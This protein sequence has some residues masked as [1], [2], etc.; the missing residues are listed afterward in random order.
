MAVHDQKLFPIPDEDM[1][2][3]DERIP[4]FVMLDQKAIELIHN[5][6]DQ[7]KLPNEVCQDILLL[8]FAIIQI[9]SWRGNGCETTIEELVAKSF[10]DSED[11]IDRIKWLDDLKLIRGALQDR[12]DGSKAI[13]IFTL[14]TPRPEEVGL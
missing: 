10:I 2:V 7:E 3:Y 11:F 12:L 5:K 8:Y 4:P 1:I 6:F 14:P 9:T 13:L